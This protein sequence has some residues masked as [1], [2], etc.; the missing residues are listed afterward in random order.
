MKRAVFIHGG[1]NCLPLPLIYLVS[2]RFVIVWT[3]T[4]CAAWS[5]QHNIPNSASNIANS[6]AEAILHAKHLLFRF[7]SSSLI[8]LRPD[9]SNNLKPFVSQQSLQNVHPL[10]PSRPLH[11]PHRPTRLHNRFPNPSMLLQCP[12]RLVA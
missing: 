11:H 7:I 5:I 1:Y 2:V 4:Y 8:K 12:P 10:L 3:S 6:S 9:H